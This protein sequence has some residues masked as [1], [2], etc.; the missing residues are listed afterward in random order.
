MTYEEW[1]AQVPENI[2]NDPSRTAIQDDTRAEIRSVAERDATAKLAAW[3]RFERNGFTEP[4]LLPGYYKVELRKLEKTEAMMRGGVKKTVH[5]PY[6][7][8]LDYEIEEDPSEET[9]ENK[10]KCKE[11]G[12]YY[13]QKR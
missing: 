7:G 4:E 5:C 2:K 3:K 1:L 8:S 9:S 6:C 13:T 11:C 12:E 10:F